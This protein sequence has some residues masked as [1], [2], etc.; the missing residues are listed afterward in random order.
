MELRNMIV[1]PPVAPPY[2]KGYDARNS[3]VPGPLAEQDVWHEGE[4]LVPKTFSG[5]HDHDVLVSRA[6]TKALGFN[7][8]STL[9]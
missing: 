6:M 5:T 4:A 7:P 2:P 9:W 3:Q 1:N 8:E